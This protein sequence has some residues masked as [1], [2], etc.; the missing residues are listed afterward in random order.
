MG[1]VRVFTAFAVNASC[2][3]VGLLELACRAFKAVREVVS[4]THT[5]GT[6]ATLVTKLACR[7]PSSIRVRASGAAPTQSVRNLQGEGEIQKQGV[8]G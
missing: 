2:H 5:S 7:L 3:A 6:E 8:K 1:I 4:C